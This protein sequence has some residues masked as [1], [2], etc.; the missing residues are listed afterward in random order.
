MLIDWFTVGA[1]ALN[2]VVLVWLLKRFLYQPVLNAIA[3]REDLIARQ[4]ADAQAV[5]RGAEQLRQSFV[6]KSEAFDRERGYLLDQALRQARDEHDRLIEAAHQAA[7]EVGEKRREALRLESAALQRSIADSARAEVFEV[8]RR[9]LADLADVSLQTEVADLFVRR[10]GE[11][12]EPA[13]GLLAE[14]LTGAQAQAVVRSAFNLADAQRARI[15][16]AVDAC[17]RAPVSLTFITA[18]EM[19]LGIELIGAGRKIAWGVDQY[20]GELDRAIAQRLAIASQPASE[21]AGPGGQANT[22]SSA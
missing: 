5:K 22:L 18:P 17:A 19:I 1:Q 16:A 8:T 9:V 7:D 15:Q 4:I 10:L 3:A 11:L 12:Q 21:K 2:F 14:A 6:D 13:R 20:L